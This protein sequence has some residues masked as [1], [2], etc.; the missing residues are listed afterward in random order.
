MK[1]T[2]LVAMVGALTMGWSGSVEAKD[3][4]YVGE[5]ECL[6]KKAA[7]ECSIQ[8]AEYQRMCEGAKNAT[9]GLWNGFKYGLNHSV[10]KYAQAGT[11]D[12]YEIYWTKAG[13]CYIRIDVYGMLQGTSFR[14]SLYG[15][16]Y[17]FTTNEKGEVLAS[18][19]IYRTV[20]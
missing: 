8:Q 1:K 5:K 15:Q 6:K 10:K 4:Y 19:T 18:G 7:F 14:K 17:Q 12:D 3:K 13:Y 11:I 9:G 2:I 16:V 20:R